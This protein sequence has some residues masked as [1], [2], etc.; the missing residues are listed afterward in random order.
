MSCSIHVLTHHDLD[1]VCSLL[2]LIW[3]FP[4]ATV[5][6]TTVS[7]PHEFASKFQNIKINNYDKVF[8]TDISI[9][10][11][12]LPLIDKENVVFIDHHTSSMNARFAYATSIIK[13]YSSCALLIFKSFKDKISVN[14]AQKQLL[15]YVDDYD[16][17]QLKFKNSWKINCL[18]W[19]M[20]SSNIGNFLSD[21]SEGFKEFSAIQRTIIDN[22]I[23]KVDNTIKNTQIHKASIN[24][25]GSRWNV[26][27][28]FASFAINDIAA[29]IITKHSY[30]IAIIINLKTSRVSFRKS[31]TC[32]AN[33]SKLAQHLCEGSGHEESAGGP[34]TET[35]L[36]FSKVFEQP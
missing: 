31:K 35:F 22:Y 2:T 16:S 15:I 12:D 10:E 32:T 24:I 7:N 19:E 36:E 28:A 17:Y 21:Y 27:A 1:G 8:I 30:D 6:Y 33:M 13:Q 14:S 9:L 5:T 23:Q 29:H 11:Q 20:Y 18:F 34:L 25:Q 3:A 26:G 4:D